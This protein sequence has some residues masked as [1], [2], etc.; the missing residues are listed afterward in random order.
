MQNIIDRSPTDVQYVADAAVFYFGVLANKISTLPGKAEFQVV[1]A[2]R[3]GRGWEYAHYRVFDKQNGISVL[4][5]RP[6]NA[7]E[8]AHFEAWLERTK[9]DTG[10][11]PAVGY[12]KP[13]DD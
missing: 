4:E 10:H 7:A 13:P 6:L 9:L 3:E 12:K 2:P 1:Y 8:Q 11:M 5:D